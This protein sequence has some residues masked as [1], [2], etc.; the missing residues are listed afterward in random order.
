MEVRDPAD[1]HRRRR[2]T[3]RASEIAASLCSMLPWVTATPLGSPV[4]PE[5][6]CRKATVSAVM[7]GIVHES[8]S[9]SGDSSMAT[10][11]IGR[12]RPSPSM[13]AASRSRSFAVVSARLLSASRSIPAT[14]FMLRSSWGSGAGTAMTPA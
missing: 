8:A 2:S 11:W 5:V 13:P 1:E 14:R 9:A 3:P 12:A 10:H 7:C 4:E 6:Y